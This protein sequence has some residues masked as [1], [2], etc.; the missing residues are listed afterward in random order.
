MSIRSSS[1][2]SRL[3]NCSEVKVSVSLST[4]QMSSYRVTDQKP[5]FGSGSGVPVQRVLAAERVELA[6]GLVVP[7]PVEVGEVDLAQ[8]D[9]LVAR[10]FWSSSDESR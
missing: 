9:G 7:E 10:S 6:P 2:S 3:T 1:T 8:R 4:A 5:L